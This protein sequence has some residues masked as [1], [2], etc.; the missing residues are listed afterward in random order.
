[1]YPQTQIPK[2]ELRKRS[3]TSRCNAGCEPP[4]EADF[5]AALNSKP[6]ET[7]MRTPLRSCAKDTGLCETCT[8]LPS[9]SRCIKCLARQGL[10]A[11][12]FGVGAQGP[13]HYTLHPNPLNPIPKLFQTHQTLLRVQARRRLEM[14]RAAWKLRRQGFGG[15]WGWG[16]RD[17]GFWV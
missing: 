11:L 2:Q 6:V 3:R 12:E 4:A 16:F 8:S 10:R 14:S 13:T 17:V 5:K 7:L 1:M 15:V 9:G